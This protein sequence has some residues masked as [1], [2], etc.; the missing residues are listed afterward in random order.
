MLEFIVMAGALC[1][2]LIAGATGL[3]SA[4]TANGFI[5]V[6]VTLVLAALALRTIVYLLGDQRAQRSSHD[7]RV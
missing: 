5:Q 4:A 7:H 2:V 1:W 3:I 6:I